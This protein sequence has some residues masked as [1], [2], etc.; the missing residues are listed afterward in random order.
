M[1]TRILVVDDDKQIRVLLSK[2]LAEMG[3]FSVEEAETAQE[4]LQKI[5]TSMFD[6]ALVDFKL[7]DMDGVQLIAEIVKLRPGM[8]AVLLTGHSSIDT[9][10]EA[11]KKGASDYLTKPVDLDEMLFRLK[12]VLKEKKRFLSIEDMEWCSF[13]WEK[14]KEMKDKQIEFWGGDGFTRLR[15]VEVDEREGNIFMITQD[16]KKTWPL[17]F[18]KLEEVHGKIHH[19]EMALRAYEIDKHIPTWGNYV[20]GLF[21]YLGCDKVLK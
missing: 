13:S 21:E 3:E 17:R 6:L 14:I 10:V 8:L 16:G 19:R 11:M 12:R 20:T 18:Q 7:P 5:E 4:A 1:G 9:A 15:I 2:V